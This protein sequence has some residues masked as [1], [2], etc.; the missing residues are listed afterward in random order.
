MMGI[1]VS[2]SKQ[3][4][5]VWNYMMGIIVSVYKQSVIVWNYMMG[6]LAQKMDIQPNLVS[7]SNYTVLLGHGAPLL[8]FVLKRC[9]A[10]R[11]LNGQCVCAYA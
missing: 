2:V 6:I 5:I 9:L 4:V 11:V 10:C 1:I 7:S 8:D 3:S